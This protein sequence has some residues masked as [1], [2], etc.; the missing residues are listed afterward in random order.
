MRLVRRASHMPSRPRPGNYRHSQVA[1]VSEV[2]SPSPPSLVT[3]F[4]SVRMVSRNSGANGS[5]LHAAARGWRTGGHVVL[6]MV[7]SD[8]RLR[9]PEPRVTTLPRARADGRTLRRPAREGHPCGDAA[10]CRTS[11]QRT[12]PLAGGPRGD[13][14]ARRG[15]VA[16]G[17]GAA[18]RYRAEHSQPPGGPPAGGP[19]ADFR[20]PARPADH[21]CS[22]G[23]SRAR[24][25]WTG[26]DGFVSAVRRRAQPLRRGRAGPGG[27]ARHSAIRGAWCGTRHVRVPQSLFSARACACSK[28]TIQ[29]RRPG[30]ASGYKTSASLFPTRSRLPPSISRGRRSRTACGRPAS[31]C[32]SRRSSRCWAWSSI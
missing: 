13:P 2:C 7:E 19:A 22:G 30:S 32:T 10:S 24:Q 1:F 25:G 9:S 4:G 17:R 14:S 15:A 31:R 26:R 28:W 27:P 23:S 3:I 6:P 20:R 12:R 8:R 11:G 29:R 18:E 21:R 5:R 16:P